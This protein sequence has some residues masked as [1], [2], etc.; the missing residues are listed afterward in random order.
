[1]K[2]NIVLYQPEIPQNTG[3]IART[4]LLTGSVLHLIRPL[5]FQIDEKTLLRAGMD[6]WKDV[7]ICV[8]DDFFDFLEKNNNPLIYTC[9]T[10]TPH[11]YTDVEFIKDPFIMFGKE[12]KGIPDYI[13]EKYKNTAIRIPMIPNTRSLNLSNSVAIVVYEALRQHGFVDVI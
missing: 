7:D 6:Y 5:G 4:C 3:N 13:L 9:E 2:I 12:S 11:L 8:Y 1:M 10:K